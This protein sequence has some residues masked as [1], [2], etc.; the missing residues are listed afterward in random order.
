MSGLRTLHRW[1]VA[2]LLTGIVGVAAAGCVVVPVGGYAVGP[3]A[4]VVPV[5]GVVIAPGPPVFHRHGFG[6]GHGPHWRG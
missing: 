3:P 4:V 1:A 6:W 5:P 2:L